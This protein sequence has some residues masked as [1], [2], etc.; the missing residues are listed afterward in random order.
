MK[1]KGFKYLIDWTWFAIFPTVIISI[2]EPQYLDKNFSIK[3]HWLGFYSRWF[4]I[5]ERTNEIAN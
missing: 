3:F 2:N 5:K 4:W 1:Y